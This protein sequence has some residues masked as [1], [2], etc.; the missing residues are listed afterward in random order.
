MKKILF[1]LM[2]LSSK[3]VFS[4]K[5]LGTSFFGT[6]TGD[7][8]V[9]ETS[10][11]YASA[12]DVEALV[13]SI[14]A[15]YGLKNGYIIMSCTRTD[16][17]MATLD[18]KNRPYILFNPNFLKSVRRL[19]F[20]EGDIPVQSNDWPTITILSH[21]LGHHLNNH[22]INP[23]PGMERVEME[24]EADETAGFI[25]Y[26][27]GGGLNDA[28]AA[29]SDKSVSEMGSYTHPARAKRLNAVAKGWADAKKKYPSQTNQ[30]VAPITPVNTNAFY[31]LDGFNDNSNGWDV[32]NDEKKK[33]FINNSKLRVNG[34]NDTYAYVSDKNFGVDVSKDFRVSV[35][36]NWLEGLEGDGYG[37]KFCSEESTSSVNG[38]YVNAKGEYII[39][40]YANN[41]NWTSLRTW[42]PSS[43]INKTNY[44]KNTLAIEKSGSVFRFYINN[45]LVETF[46]NIQIY[47]NLFGVYIGGKLTVDFDNFELSGTKGIAQSV[48]FVDA[49]K[50]SFSESFRDNSNNWSYS[51]SENKKITFDGYKLNIKGIS[52]EYSYVVDK[53]IKVDVSKDFSISMEANWIEGLTSPGYGMRY[54]SNNATNSINSFGINAL[55][56]YVI[57]GFVNNGNYTPVRVWTASGYINKRNLGTNKLTVEKIGSVFK[58]YINNNLVE[59][60][61]NI[62]VH[63]NV[64]GPY[65]GGALTVDFDNIEING[66]K[67]GTASST[68]NNAN[69]FSFFDSFRDNSNNWPLNTSANKKMSIDGSYLQIKGISDAYA[70]V[71]EKEFSFDYSKDFKV[72]VEASWIEG[73]ENSVYGIRYATNSATKSVNS[74]GINA[75]GEYIIGGYANDADY[76]S[77]INWTPSSYINK[78]NLGANTLTVERVGSTCRYYINN[79]LVANLD[80]IKMYGNAFAPYIGGAL[81]VNFDNFSITGKK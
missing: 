74:F 75:K 70:Y 8:S 50:F 20:S 58:Y 62:Q 79:N 40:Y 38:F 15:K 7:V 17:C 21:E 64:F 54:C 23:R 27:L 68:V 56:E 10:A 39:G 19:N 9:C 52:D 48:T 67:G 26:L 59:T 72:T 12:S 22:L 14:L 66:T 78:R 77:I 71:A 3:E 35:D 60:I 51:P 31:F 37:L 53:E 25:I 18:E 63:G 13:T 16:N 47:G 45:N 57:G 29:Y 1:F 33:L 4:Q 43:Y 34:L 32:Y 2:I 30:P 36:A 65:V 55:G 46:S 61:D 42:T 76:K 28:Q 49:N 6:L 69:S 5:T 11:G 81:T 73:L 80:N 24:L 44:G 41:G